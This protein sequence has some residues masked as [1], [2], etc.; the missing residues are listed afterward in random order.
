MASFYN[1]A[2][3]HL[4]AAAKFDR[5]GKFEDALREYRSGIDYLLAAIK[6]EYAG[7]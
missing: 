4:M 5:E 2:T 1:D 6:R 7:S 3:T